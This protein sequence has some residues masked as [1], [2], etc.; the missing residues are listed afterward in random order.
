M[1]T[2][3]ELEAAHALVLEALTPTPALRWP[4]LCERLGAEAVV[5]HE[6]HNPTGA[7]KVRGGVTYVD[8]L[9]RRAPGARAFVSA[10]RGN[11][12]QSLALAALR[13]GIEPIIYVPLGN[14]TEKN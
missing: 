1:F 10:T 6:N 13:A 3:V 8:A 12:G 4:L 9:K 2:L 11:H 5:K 7:F 14:S